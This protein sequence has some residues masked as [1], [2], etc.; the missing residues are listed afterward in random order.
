MRAVTADPFSPFPPTSARPP[1]EV[2]YDIYLRAGLLEYLHDAFGAA[3]AL[4]EKAKPFA[5]PRTS[6]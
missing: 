2:A 5:P 4:F 3:L 1:R 6:R